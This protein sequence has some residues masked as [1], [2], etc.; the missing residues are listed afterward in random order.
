MV[1]S[2]SNSSYVGDEGSRIMVQGHPWAT[3]V[4]FYSKYK[5]E[6][7]AEWLKWQSGCAATVKS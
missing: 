5:K 2:I 6:G 7:L 1:V 4:R 3:N